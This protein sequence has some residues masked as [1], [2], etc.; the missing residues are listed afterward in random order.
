MCVRMRPSRRFFDFYTPAGTS[1]AIAYLGQSSV[2]SFRAI[3]QR[4]LYEHISEVVARKCMDSGP[5]ADPTHFPPKE[6][7]PAV[8]KLETAFAHSS[9]P[10]SASI[11]VPRAIS[12]AA[13]W[14]GRRFCEW[15]L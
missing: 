7:E 9:I 5:Q 15:D 6:P 4:G 1:I 8:Q 13:I 14:A 10:Y 2:S 11:V 12:S 3:I